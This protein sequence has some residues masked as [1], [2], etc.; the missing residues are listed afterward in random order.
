MFFVCNVGRSVRKDPGAA[1]FAD[2]ISPSMFLGRQRARDS[3]LKLGARRLVEL[4]LQM[5]AKAAKA[6]SE[7]QFKIQGK[8]RAKGHLKGKALVKEVASARRNLA[9]HVAVLNRTRP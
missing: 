6:L 9:E 5:L 2:P 1:A 3:G 8:V 4:R 7:E